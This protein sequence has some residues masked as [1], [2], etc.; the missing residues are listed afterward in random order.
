MPAPGMKGLEHF[1]IITSDLPRSRRFYVDVLGAE[2]NQR[3]G[4][5]GVVLAGLTI[6]LFPADEV[7]DGPMPGPEIQHHAFGISR[8]DADAWIEHLRSQG[9]RFRIENFGVRRG[10]L[11][12]E[13]PDGYHLELAMHFQTPE[14]QQETLGKHGWVPSGRD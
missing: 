3:G 9:V 14:E 6:D 13:D 2:V 1:A 4:P 11:L 10:A 7:G 12:F 5:P 8:E